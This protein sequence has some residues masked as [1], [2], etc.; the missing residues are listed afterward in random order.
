MH[1][2]SLIWTM[3]DDLKVN[4][5]LR[6]SLPSPPQSPLSHLLLTLSNALSL[7]ICILSL[8]HWETS[9]HAPQPPIDC[10][11]PLSQSLSNRRPWSPWSLP[12]R[13]PCHSSSKLF[14]FNWDVLHRRSR[15]IVTYDSSTL[16]HRGHLASI[17]YYF[18]I[19]VFFEWASRRAHPAY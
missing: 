5:F 7:N 3:S 13:W 2:Q 8:S 19:C 16:G 9:S 17:C 14:N 10:F 12:L 6:S 1:F 4:G 11:E 15:A 18:Y